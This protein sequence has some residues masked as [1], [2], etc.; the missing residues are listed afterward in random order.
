VSS[1]PPP[2]P[3]L[4]P[5]PQPVPPLLVPPVLPPPSAPAAAPPVLLW[6]RF[7]LGA[8]AALWAGCLALGIVLL[9]LREEAAGW[10]QGADPGTLLVTGV[11]LAVLGAVLHS[12]FFSAFFL[13]R[14]PWAWM[15]H[16]VLIALGL[17]S[18]CALPASIPLLVFWLRPE[19]QAW[20]GRHP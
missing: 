17:A 3:L 7:Y 20:F 8:M 11:V 14:R 2:P 18:C 12:A 13:P 5:P 6:Y 4:P 9:F 15:V 16:L 10:P 1:G 19:T